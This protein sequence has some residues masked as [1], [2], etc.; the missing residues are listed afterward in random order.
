[1]DKPWIEVQ[2]EILIVWFPHHQPIYEADL[3]DHAAFL[4]LWPKKLDWE[5]LLESLE[6]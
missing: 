3:K 1:M 5:D 4:S 2:I 6:S